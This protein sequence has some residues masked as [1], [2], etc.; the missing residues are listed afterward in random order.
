[1]QFYYVMTNVLPA[2]KANTC[3]TPLLDLDQ[4]SV[5]TKKTRYDSNI[6]IPKITVP[7]HRFLKAKIIENESIYKLLL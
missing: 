6:Q 3:L 7:K 2:H 1:M 4:C 5:T